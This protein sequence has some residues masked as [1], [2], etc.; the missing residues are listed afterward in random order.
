MKLYIANC[1]KQVHNFL[2]RVPEATGLRAQPIKE[3]GQIQISGEL[4]PEAID[5]VV[6]QHVR[7]GLIPVDDIDRAKPFIGLCYSIDRPIPATKI[8]KLMIH[9]QGILEERAEDNLKATALAN[10]KLLENRIEM[11]AREARHSIPPIGDLEIS[12]TEES[13]SGSPAK[14]NFFREGK[15]AAGGI[16]VHRSD[17]PPGRRKG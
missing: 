12:I 15:Q 16:K 5:Y 4:Q 7:Y 2:Y 13:K 17:T 1:S 14:T 6:N 11:T 8:Q 10:N 3:G 9:N